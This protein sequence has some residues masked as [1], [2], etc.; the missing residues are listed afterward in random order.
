MIRGGDIIP[1]ITGSLQSG[2]FG[3]LGLWAIA[4]AV[5]IPC[6][7]YRQAFSFSVGYGF[8]VMAMAIVLGKLFGFSPLVMASGFYG[9]RLGSYLLLRYVISEEKAKQAKSF[10]KTPR[11]QR[12]PFAASV[13]LFYAFLMTPV[14]YALRFTGAENVALQAGTIIA[15]V[16]AS[17]EA[18]ADTQKLVVKQSKTSK[19]GTFAGPTRGVYG[20]T[21]HPNYTGEVIFWLGLLVS[22]LPTFGKSIV[23]WVC[24]L[25][26]FYGIYGIMAMATKRLDE[27]QLEKYGGQEKYDAWRK[28][29]KAPIFPF[30][31]VE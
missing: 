4:S 3:V 6:T 10:D 29:V 19:E 17:L 8:S 23:G 5:V 2:P 20:L 13:A 25:L 11:L 12:I 21:R 14:L 15:W 28:S 18:I 1:L 7:L 26:G 22:G 31:N 30:L 16:G 24:S 27:K 9:A